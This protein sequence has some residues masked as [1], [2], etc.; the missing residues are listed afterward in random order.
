MSIVLNGTT[1]VTTPDVT[2]DGSLKIDASA[3]D[4]S[5]V[6]D[7]SGNVGIGTSSPNALIH[8]N[9]SAVSALLLTTN[10][11]NTNGTELKVQGDGSSYLYNRENAM[12]R[13]GTN[14]LERMRIDS[15]GRVTM[16]YQPMA[17]FHTPTQTTATENSVISWTNSAHEQ[18]GLTA[19]TSTNRMTVPVAGKYLVSLNL[20]VSSSAVNAITDGIYINIVK[21]GTTYLAATAQVM[22]NFSNSNGVEVPF[23]NTMIVNCAANDY[24]TF[25]FASIASSATIQYGSAHIYLIG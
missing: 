3:P 10:T 17:T 19:N 20:S 9:G 12:L 21:N 13:F 7:A 2:S 15:A 5:L 11:Y 23:Y 24:I 6:V 1:G 25:S 16:P 22:H 14:N 18:G 8:G 4:D